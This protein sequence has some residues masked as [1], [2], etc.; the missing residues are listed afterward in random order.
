MILEPLTADLDVETLAE[1]MAPSFGGDPQPAR[2]LLAMM[3]AH[4]ERTAAPQPWGTYLATDSGRAIGTCAFKTPLDSA[5]AV[6]IAYMTFPALQGQ[7]VA[8]RMIREITQLAFDNG[9]ALVFA[10]TLPEENASN[11]A[12]RRNGFAFAGE[13]EDPEDG[14]VWRWERAAS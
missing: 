11:R 14:R 13:R 9:A 2:E 3:V 8:T 4:L 1:R 7:R 12:L 6:E 5:R 10:N